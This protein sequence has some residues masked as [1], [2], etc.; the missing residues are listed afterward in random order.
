MLFPTA[1]GEV[2]IRQCNNTD[3][4]TIHLILND[5]AVAYRGATP[6]DCWKEPYMSKNELRREIGS[7]I[8]FGGM[9]KMTN[10]LE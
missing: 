6:A 2:M 9:K 8:V 4:E 7:G 3:F 10:W 5:A 1:V